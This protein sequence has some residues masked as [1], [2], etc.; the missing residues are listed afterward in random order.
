MGREMGQYLVAMMATVRAVATECL[1][2]AWMA[3]ERDQ[4]MVDMSAKHEAVLS[5]EK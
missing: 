3:E 5:V 1:Q 2:V 4:L